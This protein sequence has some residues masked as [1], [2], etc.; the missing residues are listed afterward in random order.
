MNKKQSIVCFVLLMTGILSGCG[1][2]GKIVRSILSDQ[3]KQENVTQNVDSEETTAPLHE[4]E[5]EIDA[6]VS[7]TERG[8]PAEMCIYT[9]EMDVYSTLTVHQCTGKEIVFTV[10][11]YGICDMSNV[12][13]VWDTDLSCYSFVF[14]GPAG[15]AAGSLIFQDNQVV[16]DIKESDLPYKAAGKYKFKWA[17]DALSD[18]ELKKIRADLGVPEAPDIKMLQGA[19]VYWAAGE[20]YTTYVQVVQDDKNIASASV[21]SITG[22]LIKDILMYSAPDAGNTD[23]VQEVDLE[24]QIEEIRDIY[25]TIQNNL[26]SFTVQDDSATGGYTTRYIDNQGNIRKISLRK[27]A[28][29]NIE[30]SNKYSI[31]YYYQ[32]LD[33]KYL[34]RFIFLWGEGEEHRIYLDENGNC[35]RYIDPFGTTYNEE[36]AEANLNSDLQQFCT[37]GMLE[38]AWAFGG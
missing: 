37:M 27:G 16:L 38:I 29:S 12:I 20:R 2:G 15:Y 1:Q 18:E 28:Y 25:Y 22:E 31:E 32:I 24:T 5:E 19:S 33:G 3:W 10:F 7:D 13:A 36:E 14:D 11:W 23:F 34:L 26:D 9:D 8:N 21:D 17:F 4:N 35:I 6:D 30:A